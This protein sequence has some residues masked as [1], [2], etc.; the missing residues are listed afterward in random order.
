MIYQTGLDKKELIRVF[1]DVLRTVERWCKKNNIELMIS[2]LWGGG[3]HFNHKNFKLAGFDFLRPV[4]LIGASIGDLKTA[5]GPRYL[6]NIR[7]LRIHVSIC[8]KPHKG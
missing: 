8:P 6:V 5:V 4:S 1:G 2:E 3:H 7:D